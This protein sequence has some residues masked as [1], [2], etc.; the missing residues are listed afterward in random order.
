[1]GFVSF[2]A[3]AAGT[4]TGG[5]RLTLT[6]EQAILEIIEGADTGSVCRLEA[7]EDGV[8]GIIPHHADPDIEAGDAT[9][10]H[11]EARAEHTDRMAR[12]SSVVAGI[13]SGEERVGQVQ[14]G[15]FQLAPDLEMAMVSAQTTKAVGSGSHEAQILLVRERW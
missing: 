15:L 3:T 1:M 2:V 13:G 8:E 6:L 5:A 14:V 10:H 12:R 11:S 4:A 7:A 9:L